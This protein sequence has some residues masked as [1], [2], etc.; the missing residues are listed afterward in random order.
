MTA[1]DTNAPQLTAFAG[2]RLIATGD[3]HEVVARTWEYLDGGGAEPL[4][5]FDDGTGRTVDLDLRGR[6]DEALARL[7]QEPEATA[8]RRTGPGRPKLGVVS[9]EVSLLP[10]HWE[11]LASQPGGASVALRK[12]VETARRQNA[13][14]DLAR[15]RRDAAHKFMWTM[16]G[17]MEAFEEASRALYAAEYARLEQLTEPWPRDVRDHVARLVHALLAAEAAD[18]AGEQP[19]TR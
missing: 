4:A 12:L 8:E 17:D 19:P 5:V 18:V 6:L 1:S 2:V 11:W 13:G 7:P 14:K 16:A 15:Q 10:R 9:R 3:L